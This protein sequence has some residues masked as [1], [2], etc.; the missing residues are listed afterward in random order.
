MQRDP[1]PCHSTRL[2]GRS[3]CARVG[4]GPCRM[5]RVVLKKRGIEPRCCTQLPQEGQSTELI[6]CTWPTGTTVFP[7][8]RPAR[9]T[10]GQPVLPLSGVAIVGGI[11]VILIVLGLV[12]HGVSKI[13]T[14]TA[15][16]TA[17]SAPLTT[18]QG[19]AVPPPSGM[20]R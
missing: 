9:A 18:G 16:N 7:S 19:A 4:V 3:R 5:A 6:A 17:A 10:P 14:D 15:N 20:A 12:L 11:V 8:R 2:S 13:V 1:H